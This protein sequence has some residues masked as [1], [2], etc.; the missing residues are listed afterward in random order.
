MHNQMFANFNKYG[1]EHKQYYETLH[2]FLF[3]DWVYEN[4]R[5]WGLWIFKI[6]QCNIDLNLQLKIQIEF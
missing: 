3:K 2:L 6:Y 4:I 1:K 5:L